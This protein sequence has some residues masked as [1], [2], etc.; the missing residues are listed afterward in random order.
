MARDQVVGDPRVGATASSEAVGDTNAGRI[1]VLGIGN[2]LTGDD[3][4]GPT[5]VN[6]LEAEW[7]LPP[8]V[9]VLDA[10]TPGMDLVALASGAERIIVVDTV[11]TDG[12]PGTLKVYDRETLLAK[13]LTP[14]VNPHA[15]GLIESLFTLDLSG[16]GPTGVCLIGVVPEA[17]DVGIG[18][19]DALTASVPRVIDVI[20]ETLRE[21]GV[22]VTPCPEPAP[23][24]LWWQV[25]AR[26]A[27]IEGSS[28]RRGG[29]DA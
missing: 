27:F 26:D 20:V 28:G 11:L 4:L 1:F 17:T 15:P 16:D 25:A 14:R 18:M 7:V 29:P 2:V 3:A 19:S 5:V 12:P 10:G 23:P 22:S 21:W 8:D 6:T 24:D 9:V 13:P